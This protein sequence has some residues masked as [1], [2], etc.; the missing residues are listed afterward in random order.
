MQVMEAKELERRRKALG[1]S[2]EALAKELSI[3]PVTVWRWEN[4]ERQIPAFLP[5]AMETIERKAK[6]GRKQ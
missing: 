2:R 6:R 5:L 4:C 1:L 3:S